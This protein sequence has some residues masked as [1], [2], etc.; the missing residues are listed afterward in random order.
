MRASWFRRDLG[1]LVIGNV[2]SFY[3]A[4]GARYIAPH[5]KASSQG[6]DE[7]HCN[8]FDLS[9]EFLAGDPMMIN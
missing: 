5:V 1:S 9:V 3:P 4:Q 6:Q 8:D 2:L 7:L